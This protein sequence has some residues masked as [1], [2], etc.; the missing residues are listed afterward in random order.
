MQAD[1]PSH[2]F[3]EVQ[4]IALQCLD[5]GGTVI[6]ANPRAARALLHR[7]SVE[8]QAAGQ[9]AWKTP[10]VLDWESWLD[11]L[12]N[13][14]LL[15]VPDAPLLLSSIQE[16]SIWERIV[17][18]LAA[19]EIIARLAA[20][21]WKLLSDHN[22]HRERSRPWQSGGA[23]AQA[24][25]TWA[26]VFER[27]CRKQQYL[28]RSE[29]PS[30]LTSAI[31]ASIIERPGEIALVGFDRI[32]PSQ[33]SLLSAIEETGCKVREIAPPPASRPPQCVEAA[34]PR[35]EIRTVAWW[36]RRKLESNP[37]AR[38][39]VIL[40]SIDQSRAEIERTFRSVLTPE[41]SGIEETAAMPF[42]FSLGQP[43]S[44]VGIVKAALLLLR[45]LIE[46]ISQSEVSWLLLSGFL[47]KKDED[48]I[49]LA[50]LDAQIRFRAMLP[51]QIPIE[52]LTGYQ[53]QGGALSAWRFLNRLKDLQQAAAS[54]SIARRSRSVAEWVEF[55]GTLLRKAAWPGGSSLDSLEFQ[56]RDRWERLKSD[57]A[58][59]GF[60]SSRL[61]YARFVTVLDRY[62]RATIFSTESRDSPIQIMGPFESS[63]QSFDAIWF[64]GMDEQRWPPTA[65]PHPLLP[66][67]LQHRLGMPHSSLDQDWQL[68]AAAT[69]RIAASASECVF[70]YVRQDETGDLRPS[71]LLREVGDTA[72]GFLASGELRRGLQVI[73]QPEQELLTEPSTTD[74]PPVPWPL[75]V[76]AGGADILKHQS[77]CPFRAFAERRL[78]AKQL[79][80]AERGL[81]ARSRGSI[82]HSVLERLWSKENPVELRL[83][84][85]ED[86]FRAEASGRLHGILETH[87]A[88][89]FAK[90]TRD[91]SP[92][93][94]EYLHIERKRMHDLLSA[95]LREEM[96]RTPFTVLDIEK[97]TRT[98]VNGLRLNL[99]VDRVDEVDEGRL[100]IDYKSGE[101][102]SSMWEDDRPE[103]PQLL[104]YAVHGDVED[105]RGLLFAQV[106]T[107]DLAF[108]GRVVNT[109]DLIASP[110]RGFPDSA[111]TPLTAEMLNGWAE[112]LGHL[113]DEF[114][115]GEASVSPKHY[116]KTCKFCP[117]PA[118]CRVAETSA[119]FDAAGQSGEIDDASPLPGAATGE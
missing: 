86:L 116:P 84:G 14:Y 70:S 65:Q 61:T 111:K 103:E 119:R 45:W 60:D 55:S 83:E 46:P 8:Q 98:E 76:E 112:G 6:T 15:Q 59:L 105:L 67:E 74:D 80:I 4:H 21:A 13:Q 72:S 79:E 82:L 87:I 41:S 47:S 115:A 51:P 88:N 39:A 81:T 2:Q 118:L 113:A 38:L 48:I 73:D 1:L 44:N 32:L 71:I 34:D 17:S 66:R 12:W 22:A 35:D 69:R 62:T 58:G 107:G 77:A 49:G 11:T 3:S 52:A 78:G 18:G 42:E 97:E 28:T 92:W 117:L 75:E 56:A 25:R 64:L 50:A 40:Q 5:R 90:Y 114:I 26:E 95:W 36:T 96:K 108:E 89:A 99:R 94:L 104:L 31:R 23:D 20:D 9:A 29:V 85:R 110:S 33:Q 19:P 43:L 37:A 53:P 7:Y 30:L 10:L 101:V 57:L 63:G 24:F 102:S 109:T 27:E 106:R 54:A 93:D 16:L 68:A 100:I 91:L